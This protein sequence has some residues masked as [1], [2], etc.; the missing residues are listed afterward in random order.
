MSQADATLRNLG[1]SR[2]NYMARNDTNPLSICQVNL[3]SV[4]SDKVEPIRIFIAALTLLSLGMTLGAEAFTQKSHFF[5]CLTE[6]T[7]SLHSQSKSSIS[8]NKS[9]S[10]SDQKENDCGDPCHLGNCHFGHCS[11]T[12]SRHSI[13]YVSVELVSAKHSR[14]QVA[15]DDPLL[16][17][18]RRPP[19]RS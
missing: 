1:K 11:F 12:I 7:S 13:H 17:G 18:P 2:S 15:V 4:V 6:P 9:T 10:Q 8:Q 19:R 5:S 14:C 16:E 3:N